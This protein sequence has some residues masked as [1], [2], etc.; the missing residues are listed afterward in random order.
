MGAW[1]FIT[2]VL[3]VDASGPGTWSWGA[4]WGGSGG[5]ASLLAALLGGGAAW[6]RK[7]NCEKHGCWRLGRHATAA[8]HVVCRRHH[9]EGAPSAQDIIDAHNAAKGV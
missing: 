6:A 5:D 1:D 9:P 4:F 7:H 8:G 3:G 2:H